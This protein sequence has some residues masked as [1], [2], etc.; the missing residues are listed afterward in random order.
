MKNYILIALIA[1]AGMFTSCENSLDY[2]SVKRAEA[3][4]ETGHVETPNGFSVARVAGLPEALSFKESLSA[5]LAPVRVPVIREGSE[6]TLYGAMS[7]EIAASF[8]A[9]GDKIFVNDQNQILRTLGE[10]VPDTIQGEIVAINKTLGRIQSVDV[11]TGNKYSP[12]RVYVA[13]RVP[14]WKIVIGKTILAKTG[15]AHQ[16]ARGIDVL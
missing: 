3:E 13:H 10:I 14:E 2:K 16:N 11:L 12:I 4:L 15:V 5:H 1:V 8:L 9:M 7:S 6:D